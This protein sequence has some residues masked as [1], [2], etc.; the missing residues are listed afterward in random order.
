MS[1]KTGE[2]YWSSVNTAKSQYPY[3]AEDIDC[4]VAIV[5]GGVAG[6]LC[7]Y[8][9]AKEKIDTALV[10]AGLF[11]QGSTCACS[12]VLE[13]QTD[14]DLGDLRDL[15]GLEN[16]V[17]AYR[18][19]QKAIDAIE[20]MAKDLGD[21]G[22]ERRDGF[23][24]SPDKE[25]V[26]LI[27]QEFRL[28]KHND[29]GVEYFDKVEAAERFSFEVEAGIYSPGL[30]AEI[31]PYKFD[32]ELI[33][34]AAELGLRAYENTA[35][36]AVTAQEEG[37]ELSTGTRHRIR[38]KKMVNATGYSGARE[39]GRV[40]FA[41][42]TFFVVTAP[43]GGF[44]GWHNR[45]IIRDNDSPSTFLRT[46]PDDRILIGGL[47]SA[48][49][50][51]RG[52]IAGVLKFPAAS[53]RKYNLLERRLKEMFIGIEGIK[54]EYSFS[55]LLAQTADGLPYVGEDKRFPNVYFDICP[56]SN[57]IVFAYL[58]AQ[59]IRDLYKGESSPDA[60]LFAIGR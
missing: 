1:I 55:G 7:A 54:A 51:S 22:F 30:C 19:C 35:V 56:G 48:F 47:D 9:L 45:S 15:I 21:V 46:L 11:G 59:A 37:I 49:P 32:Q 53:Q 13:Y 29:L 20:Q 4:D 34:A 57:G 25:G 60:E 18:A 41:K 26:E 44:N 23:Y 3:L 50:G 14:L 8:T 5:G 16:S 31:D 28:R 52:K 36:E 42:N 17:R 10:D 33:G 43:V 24:Y 40:V 58:A 27:N 12:S 38:A 6:A 39:L 2:S